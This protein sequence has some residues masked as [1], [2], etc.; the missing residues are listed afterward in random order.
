MK[1]TLKVKNCLC[2]KRSDGQM[3]IGHRFAR[4]IGNVGGKF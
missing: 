2:V 3:S 4:S 1:T